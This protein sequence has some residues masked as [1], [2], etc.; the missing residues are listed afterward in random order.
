MTRSDCIELANQLTERK[1]EKLINLNLLFSTTIQ[2]ICKRQRFWWRKLDVTFSLTQG[3][4]TYDFTD[5]TL[6]FS[7]SLAEIAVEEMITFALILQTSPSLNAP[8][9]TPISDPQG[10][11]AM[12]NNPT[13]GQP[14]RYTMG[15]DGYSVLR[16]DPP[17]KTYTAEMTFWAMPMVNTDQSSNT[18]PLIPPFYHNTIVEGIEA[19]INKRVYG[20]N[21]SRYTD[22]VNTYEASL[23][24]M[25]MR[26]Q[27]TTNLE[28]QWIT[29]DSSS[30]I[31]STAPN[32][33]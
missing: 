7:Q 23:L 10:I 3:T 22:S 31:Q 15:I 5:A 6:N 12:K 32:T 26:P 24:K 20:P 2:D 17:D 8:E 33:P 21:D 16:V 9:L 27:F 30:I 29:N 19:R 11:R 28:R 13:Q 4:K 1:G 18:I 25:A 14:S